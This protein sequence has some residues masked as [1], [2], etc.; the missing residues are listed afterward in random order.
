ADPDSI[1][2]LY[3]ELIA[4]RAELD[5]PVEMLDAGPGLVAYRRGDHAIAVNLGAEP[6]PI[7]GAGEV[8]IGA[9]VLANGRMIPPNAGCVTRQV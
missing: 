4:L 7:P 5:G 3:R 9:A 2:N 8:L 1:L 6:A